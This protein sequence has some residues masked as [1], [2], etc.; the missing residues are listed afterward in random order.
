MTLTRQKPMSDGNYGRREMMA[1]ASSIVTVSVAGIASADPQQE[2]E[3]INTQFN[4]NNDAELRQFVRNF[5]DLED[6]EYQRELL[7]D[8]SGRRLSAVQEARAPTSYEMEVSERPSAT[9][10]EAITT[11]SSSETWTY[12]LRGESWAGTTTYRHHHRISFDIEDRNVL[13]IENDGWTTDLAISY[14]DEGKNSEWIDITSGDNSFYSFRQRKI[15]YAA[16][17]VLSVYPHSELLGDIAGR[18]RLVD[19]DADDDII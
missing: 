7:N 17:E 15:T 18:T 19:A 11:A 5:E 4:P 9:S 8:L 3:G 16:G 2:D 6:E 1:A 10:T 12:T 14:H 13:N